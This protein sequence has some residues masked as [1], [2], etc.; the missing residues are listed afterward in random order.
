MV[1]AAAARANYQR[2][3]YLLLP[4][5]IPTDVCANLASAIVEQYLTLKSAG[6]LPDE[7]GIAAGNLNFMAGAEG[8]PL[9]A[10]LE[11]AGI[12]QIVERLAGVQ[13]SA[14]GI[15]GNLNLPGS[16]PQE[17]HTDSRRDNMF[18]IANVML[19]DCSPENGA[20]ELVESSH[21]EPLAYWQMRRQPWRDRARQISA[22]QGDVLIRPST[23]WHRGTTNPSA[24]PRPMAAQ[25]FAS[26]PGLDSTAH[27]G[28]IRF[29]GNRYYGR[30]AR[31][32]EALAM[33][34]PVLDESLRRARS[35]LFDRGG[36]G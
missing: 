29:R 12:P 14:G 22:R 16:R 4:G 6:N 28:P 1:A 34:L 2:D 30:F 11:A 26:E 17:L 24:K 31:V 10:A 32:K 35:M 20:L 21:A 9:S 5:A 36:L 33:H 8:L 25:I 3:G 7:P 23:L 18:M 27:S 15:T 13:L 19:V